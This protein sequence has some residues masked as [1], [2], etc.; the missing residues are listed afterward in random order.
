MA[1]DSLVKRIGRWIVRD[2]GTH[3]VYGFPKKYARQIGPSLDQLLSRAPDL[4]ETPMAEH[5]APMHEHQS[6]N[7]CAQSRTLGKSPETGRTA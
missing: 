5:Q 4:A 1:N 3:K 6:D 7:T 2:L